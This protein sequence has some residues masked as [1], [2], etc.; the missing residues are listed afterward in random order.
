MKK[1]T[2]SIY[3]GGSSYTSIN[4]ETGVLTTMEGMGSRT[5]TIRVIANTNSGSKVK[6]L[7]VTVKA[8]VYP[9]SSQTT[10]S[11]SSKLESTRTTYQLSFSVS[12]ITGDMVATWTL[13]GM[14]GYAEIESYDNSSCVVKKLAETSNLVQGTLSCA[15]KKRYNNANLFTVTKNVK[16]VNE[17]VAE[18]DTGIVTALYNAGLCANPNYITKEEA[19]LV[20]DVDLQPGTSQSTSIFYSQRYNIKSFDGFKYFIGVKSI[21]ERTFYG[22][23]SLTSIVIPE[24]VTSIGGSCFEGCSSLT[25]I[26]LPSTLTS[27][28]DQ[29]FYGCTSLSSIISHITTA[30]NVLYETFGTDKGSYTGRNTYNTGENTLYVP[31][32]ATGYDTGYWLDPLQNAEKCGFTLS[33]TL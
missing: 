24:G 32:G 17:R 33:A 27:I 13:S 15:L 28:G 3:S 23:S 20:T 14:E 2:W 31:A 25:S 22:C 18:T 16:V 9:S 4:A 26:T 19:A 21:K 10:M 1:L 6:D 11:G 7:T 12:G 5:L 29:C 8:R 30:P